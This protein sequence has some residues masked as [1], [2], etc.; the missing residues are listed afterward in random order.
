MH[1]LNYSG[2]ESKKQFAVHDSD[3]SVS[4]K[5]G[6]GNQSWYELVDSKHGYN[7]INFEKPCLN[8]V[9]GK[10]NDK[11]F[12]KSGNKSVISLEYVRK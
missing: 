8:S 2:Q 5:Q 11:A 1:R 9:C 3:T 7:N 12:V 6:Q 4:L 10:A